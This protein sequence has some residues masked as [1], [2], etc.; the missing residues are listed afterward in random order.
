MTDIAIIGGG[1][2]GIS[3]AL[4]ARHRGK[5]ALII[6]SPME[7]SPLARAELI[8]NYP[9]FPE[10]SGLELLR[11]LS[12]H[13]EKSGVEFMRGRAL[14]AMPLGESIGVS[15]GSD[16]VECRALILACGLSRAKPFPG[17]NEFMGRGVSYCA[18][19]DGMLYR[20]R[21]VA[22][23]GFS[24]DSR[25]EA[26]Y[27]ASIGCEVEYFDRSRAKN[28]VISGADRVETLSADGTDY[29]VDC[30]FILRS[31]VAPTSLMPALETE[32]G[33]IRVSPDLSTSVPGVFAAG[34][35]IGTPYQVAKAVGDGNTAAL[36]ASKYIENKIKEETTNGNKASH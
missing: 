20:N 25:E 12:A 14:S 24:S 8:D 3:A 4:T 26:D 7:D 15:V 9:G 31:G 27:L 32:N 16:F 35:C 5:S 30:V 6:S 1:P 36:S 23:L 29:K 19:C 10:I 33:V 22:V 18:T 13:A 21:R 2:A 17:E 28:Y 34:D 11:A